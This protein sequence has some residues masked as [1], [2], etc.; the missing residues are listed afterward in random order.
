MEIPVY[1]FGSLGILGSL[2][3]AYNE[4]ALFALF[5]L[6]AL[7]ASDRTIEIPVGSDDAAGE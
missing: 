1:V 6:F 2:G 3:F 7:Y 5:A 4:P